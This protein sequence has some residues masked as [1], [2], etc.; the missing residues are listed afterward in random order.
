MKGLEPI[1]TK[2]PG[3]GAPQAKLPPTD[4]HTSRFPGTRGIPPVEMVTVACQ[5]NEHGPHSG[6]EL[7]GSQLTVPVQPIP[8]GGTGGAYNTPPEIPGLHCCAEA[9]PQ[10]TRATAMSFTSMLDMLEKQAQ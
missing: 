8:S 10:S 2:E 9:I 1:C 6:R 5:L 3:G 4:A 7:G